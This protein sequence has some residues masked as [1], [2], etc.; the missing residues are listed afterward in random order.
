MSRSGGSPTSSL[1][2]DK[3]PMLIESFC[4]VM[5]VSVSCGL[6]F[7]ILTAVW[8]QAACVSI[9]ALLSE[10]MIDLVCSSKSGIEICDPPPLS[11]AT[12]DPAF[13]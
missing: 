4:H 5:V 6:I 11:F 12:A 9:R 2:N 8:S 7:K 13:G 1:D 10:I 3:E